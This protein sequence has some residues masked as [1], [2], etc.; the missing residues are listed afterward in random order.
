MFFFFSNII[1]LRPSLISVKTT[2]G[3]GS[4]KQG[5][6]KTHGSPL[7]EEDLANVKKKFDMNPDVKFAIPDDV[8]AVYNEMKKSGLEKETAWNELFKNYGKYYNI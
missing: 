2:I 8:A 1:F 3:L 5:T 6:E 7:G 4:I